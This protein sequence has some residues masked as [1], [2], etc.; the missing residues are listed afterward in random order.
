MKALCMNK[1]L[2]V[3]FFVILLWSCG[4]AKVAKP[5]YTKAPKAEAIIEDLY[6]ESFD[7]VSMSAKISGK[8]TGEDQSFSFK[9]NIKIQK[10]S[11]IWLTISP[12]LGLELGRVLI[13][14]DSVHFINRF[15][16]TYFRSSYDDLTTRIKSPLTYARIQALL[17]G[18]VMSDLQLKKYYSNI[19]DQKFVL[20]S[21]SPKQL[22]KI[23]RSRRKPKQEV[24]S[25]TV[26]PE[27]SKIISQEFKNYGLNQSLKI[28][29]Q[30]FESYDKKWLAESVE[31]ILE[32]SQSITL[33]LS[34]SKINLN[35]ELKFPFSAP[36]SYEIIH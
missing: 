7:F 5:L 9:G 8:Y 30:D 32:T 33:S 35:K 22:K 14:E 18:N 26:N 1:M 24:F 12:G 27:K 4:S 2:I 20:C 17:I 16:K 13:D 25:T 15:D 31:L 29:Y 36:S 6:S 23:E 34:Y 19:E 21:I 3:L 11:I 28:N 10:D